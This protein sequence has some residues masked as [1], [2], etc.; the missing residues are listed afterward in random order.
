MDPSPA[1]LRVVLILFGGSLAAVIAIVAWLV[2]SGRTVQLPPDVRPRPEPRIRA[3]GADR[4][5]I[6]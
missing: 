5:P 3:G 4:V 6:P 2:R 1:Q